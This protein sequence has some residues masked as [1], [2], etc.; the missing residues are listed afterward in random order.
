MKFI[1]VVADTN[2][3][4]S[5]MFWKGNEAKILKL[6]EE[7]EIK[8]LTSPALLDELRRVLMHEELGLDERTIGENVQYVL[9]T[10][11]LV[12]P[13]RMVKVI[14]E[15]PSDNRVLE[16]A[17]GGRAKYVISGDKHLL[18]IRKFRGIRIVR[19]K[20]FLDILNV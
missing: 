18:Q 15:D 20:E 4:F 12:S 10:A 13:R 16:C 6:A 17:L 11:E 19:A 3:L 7:G 2:I 5:A 1:K 14:R 9:S 8:L